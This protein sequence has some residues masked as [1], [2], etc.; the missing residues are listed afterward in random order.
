MQAQHI[1][2]GFSKEHKPVAKVVPLLSALES[3]MPHT[4][5]RCWTNRRTRD[6]EARCCKDLS[7]DNCLR[8]FRRALFVIPTCEEYA[9]ASRDEFHACTAWS[10]PDEHFVEHF[11]APL[12]EAGEARCF[13]VQLLMPSSIGSLEVYDALKRERSGD[14]CVG[15]GGCPWA[16][17]GFCTPTA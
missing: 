16:R 4:H 15:F 12:L 14:Q 1:Y 3:V 17:I 6:S 13:E 5:A 8:R 9:R 7:S 10:L 2:R 11:A